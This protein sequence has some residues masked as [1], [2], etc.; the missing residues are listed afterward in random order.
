MALTWLTIL[1]WLSEIN[2]GTLA[3]NDTRGQMDLVNIYQVF[4][5]E[6][7]EYTFF[8]MHMEHSP[9]KITS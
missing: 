6:A 8:S 2:N 9:G 3:L 5:P 1:V 7:A 4:H